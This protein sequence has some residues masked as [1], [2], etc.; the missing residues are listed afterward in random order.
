MRLWG[1]GKSAGW[2]QALIAEGPEKE[3]PGNSQEHGVN[4]S[5]RSQFYKL[6]GVKKG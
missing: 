3:G 6:S 2:D 1:P 5:G 4:Q